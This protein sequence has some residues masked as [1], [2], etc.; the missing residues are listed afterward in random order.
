VVHQQGA[1]VAS[2]MPH[3]KVVLQRVQVLIDVLFVKRIGTRADTE[4][5]LAMIETGCGG[6]SRFQ[7]YC[8][9]KCA[10]DAWS[11]L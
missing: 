9:E 11:S 1:L 5:Y 6:L 7:S 2:A 4:G 3:S 8:A 10:G